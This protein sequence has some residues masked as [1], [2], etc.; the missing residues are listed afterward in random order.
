[1][2]QLENDPDDRISELEG[3][4]SE[5]HDT[6]ERLTGAFDVLQNLDDTCSDM[7]DVK[8]SIEEHESSLDS[9]R[10]E[11]S[12]LDK[13]IDDLNSQIAEL[14]ERFDEFSK[15]HDPLDSDESMQHLDRLLKEMTDG[16][17]KTQSRKYTISDLNERNVTYSV[18]VA[19]KSG[20]IITNPEFYER[21]EN[22]RS[23]MR[24]NND[25]DEV[26]FDAIDAQLEEERRQAAERAARLKAE[27]EEIK[28]CEEMASRDMPRFLENMTQWV[29]KS[30][31]NSVTINN[32]L[33]TPSSSSDAPQNNTMPVLEVETAENIIYTAAKYG[34]VLEQITDEQQ[35]LYTHFRKLLVEQ[36][37]NED[38]N[39]KRLTRK[40]WLPF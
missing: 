13:R 4:I 30:K 5:L 26:D 27:K 28:R 22:L 20:F 33:S 32:A 37:K 29:K 7:Y 39:F 9:L 34:F 6:C 14:N 24:E 11:L 17:R 19:A 10:S 25:L 15:E 40:I 16:Y 1:M 8:N 35:A 36:G 12:T 21:C 23:E 38:L 2:A 3:Q 31:Q 18:Y